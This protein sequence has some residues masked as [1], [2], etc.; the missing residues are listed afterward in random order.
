MPA[1]DRDAGGPGLQHRFQY[2]EGYRSGEATEG[3]SSAREGSLIRIL[4]SSSE[5]PLPPITG[6]RLPL[7]EVVKRLA[8]DHDVTLV[9]YRWPEQTE[10][11]LPGV[12]MVS[13][14]APVRSRLWRG[15]AWVRGFRT[16]EPTQ[17]AGL[18]AAMSHAVAQLRR[19][20]SF[21][22]A[23]VTSTPMAGVRPAL[24]DL[25]AI[26]VSL[27]AWHL[28]AAAQTAA[29]SPLARP[30]RR[31]EEHRIEAFQARQL[32]DYARV[33]T[34]SDEDA[35]HLR[36]LES[37]LRVEVVPNGVDT[38]YFAAGDG[39]RD[40]GLIVF[41]GTMRWAPNVHAAQLLCREVLPLVRRRHPHAHV[42]I[43]GRAASDE[44]KRELEATEGVEVVGEVPDV[45]PWLQR[46]DI[47]ACPMIDGTGI[48]NKLLE[49]MACA[50]PTVATP[51][52]CRGTTVRDGQDLLIA[53]GAD[54][55]AA[56][57]GSLLDDAGL[58]R[59]L[60]A[61]GRAY[62]ER[63]HD[64]DAVTRRFELIY[65]QVLTGEHPGLAAEEV[66]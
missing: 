64:W 11:A 40:P 29:S 6:T 47:F 18:S 51:L 28:N 16:G 19:N 33:V 58:A 5:V 36:R 22:V 41:L 37:R 65:E 66:G 39:T 48:K 38:Q 10:A 3:C 21:D 25:P 23:H 49:A 57:I 54:G 46:A 17:V 44:L 35:E 24:G 27:D 42:A 9:G 31:I 15:S 52:A 43:V 50:A 4:I 30:V 60:G 53:D 8:A 12:R 61:A 59:A 14:D 13:L 62:V 32:R 2:A 63:H 45:R 26:M 7:L 20:Q 34:V 55:L 56:A 1:E